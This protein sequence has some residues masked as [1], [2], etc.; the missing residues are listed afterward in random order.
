MT[1]V[2]NRRVESGTP[3][4]HGT[5]FANPI[6]LGAACIVCRAVHMRERDDVAA[7]LC[8]CRYFGVPRE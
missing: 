1:R 5:I 4:T 8:Y 2:V 7:L 3:I 6:M